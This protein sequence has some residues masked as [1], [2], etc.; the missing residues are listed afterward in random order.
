MRE[1]VRTLHAIDYRGWLCFELWHRED[2]LPKRTMAED[3]KRSVE[4]LKLWLDEIN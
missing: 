2:T 4:A 1:L 3:M